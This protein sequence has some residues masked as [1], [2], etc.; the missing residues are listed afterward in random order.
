[1]PVA[2]WFVSSGFALADPQG[3]SEGEP[4][5][6]ADLPPAPALPASPAP[7]PQWDIGILLGV[8][9]VGRD[10]LWQGTDF[11]GA[12]QADAFFFRRKSSDLGLGA[13]LEL[14]TSGFFDTRLSGGVTALLPL[15]ELLV[16]E[17]HVG[18]LLLAAGDG[19]TAGLDAG[20]GIGLKGLNQSH[21]YS[22]THSFS[23]GVQHAPGTLSRAGTTLLFRLRIDAFWLLLPATLF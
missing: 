7:T 15:S 1:M 9:G 5:R 20:L 21:F 3:P 22:M 10:E 13:Y 19:A 23:V 16:V 18:P 2:S 12:V 4:L 14:G 8:C 11:C 17:G 6:A